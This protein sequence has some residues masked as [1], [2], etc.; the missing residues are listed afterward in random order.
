MKTRV[1]L[2]VVL[3]AV[4]LAGV[5]QAAGT[6][7][8]QSRTRDMKRDASCPTTAIQK[9]DRSCTTTAVQKRDRLRDGSCT[10][11]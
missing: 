4:M 9:R 3:A 2:A 6:R 1:V 11:P 5:A 8:T 10:T 7:G